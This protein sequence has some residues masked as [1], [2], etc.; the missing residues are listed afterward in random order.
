M[1][2]QTQTKL[3]W[4]D[5][6]RQVQDELDEA[7]VAARQRKWAGALRQAQADLVSPN[8]VVWLG[9]EAVRLLQQTQEDDRTR[10]P[11]PQH[12]QPKR[13]LLTLLVSLPVLILAALSFLLA[14]GRIA[15]RMQ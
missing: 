11:L 6:L 15:A 14:Y 2:K 3:Y 10:P 1:A 4:K 13:L 7:E 5:A 8:A 12:G 9:P